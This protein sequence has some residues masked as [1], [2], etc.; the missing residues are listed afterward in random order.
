M[1]KKYDVHHYMVVRV[2]VQNV[3]APDQLTAIA[4]SEDDAYEFARSSL[5]GR[6]THWDR[7]VI[8]Y[9]F[10]EES[11][12]ALVDEVGDEEYINSVFYDLS[13]EGAWKP[14]EGEVA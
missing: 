5:E 3:E 13:K 11:V 12:G 14:R 2:K 9:E 7:G 8:N 10:A 1:D 6:G 4:R